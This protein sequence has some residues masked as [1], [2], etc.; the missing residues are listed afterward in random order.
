MDWG[1]KISLTPNLSFEFFPA[2]HIV[3]AAIVRFISR[4]ARITFTGDLGRPNNIIMPPPVPLPETD[5][6][7][8]E[9]TYGNRSHPVE[10]SKQ[11]HQIRSF[12]RVPL[13]LF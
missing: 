9:S 4:G 2:G 11:W 7:V 13:R 6:L 10:E 12:E 5:Y 8:V 3:G 1:K